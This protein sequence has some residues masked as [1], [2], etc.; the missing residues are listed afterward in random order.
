MSSL[1]N[2]EKLIINRIKVAIYGYG[3]FGLKVIDELKDNQAVKVVGI[4]DN[5][6]TDAKDFRSN[7][8]VFKPEEFWAKDNLG[9]EYVVLTVLD[10]EHLIE[11][12]FKTVEESGIKVLYLPNYYYYYNIPISLNEDFLRNDCCEIKTDSIIPYIEMHVEDDC[13]LNCRGCSHFSPL[14]PSNSVVSYSNFRKDILQLKNIFSNVLKL[15]LLGGEPFLNKEIN[16]YINTA[17]MYFPYSDIRVCTNGLLIPELDKSVFEAI[18]ENNV[19]LDVSPYK[20]SIKI[21]EKIL[22][23]TSKENI[24]VQYLGDIS[25][26]EFNISFASV[27][28]GHYD[29]QCT[30]DGGCINVYNGRFSKC[31]MAMYLPQFNKIFNVDYPENGTYDLYEEGL[32]AADFKK[33]I[34]NRVD[35]C[36]YCI[37]HPMKW[38]I[39]KKGMHKAK[40][41]I[42][43]DEEEKKYDES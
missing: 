3:K 22:E 10:H 33:L 16:K 19:I 30:A 6:K 42:I 26:E 39:C 36:D 18:R 8:P 35:L 9:V 13:N 32:S 38:S 1:E 11:K 28:N 34:S 41:W 29:Y 17:R 15:R 40:D 43:D 24:V 4:I 5:Y 20:P 37:K 12:L 25:V 31:P 27:I 7:L 14:Y 21:K 2:D 23:I